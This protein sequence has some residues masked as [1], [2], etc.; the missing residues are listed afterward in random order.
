MGIVVKATGFKHIN[1]IHRRIRLLI[2]SSYFIIQNRDNL[3]Q[4]CVT[5]WGPSKYILKK[6]CRLP[7]CTVFN[8]RCID[9]STITDLKCILM[10]ICVRGQA[11]SGTSYLTTLRVSAC[12]C[13]AFQNRTSF[14]GCIVYLAKLHQTNLIILNY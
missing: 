12:V 6:L 9:R 1:A 3:H 8:H 2:F 11:R 4:K 13:V 14:W 7:K 10:P 5:V